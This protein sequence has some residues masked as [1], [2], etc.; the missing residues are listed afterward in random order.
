MVDAAADAVSSGNEWRVATPDP[1]LLVVKIGERPTRTVVAEKDR[2]RQVIAKLSS[3][4][5]RPGTNRKSI[6]QSSVGRRVY[7][8]SVDP[9]NPRNMLREDVD[10]NRVT[11][12]LVGGRFRLLRQAKDR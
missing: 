7:T 12:R 10:G 11:G 6:Y 2:A 3:V 1:H 5:K 9:A 8:Y 4:V